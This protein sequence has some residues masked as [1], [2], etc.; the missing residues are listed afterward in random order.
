MSKTSTQ[1]GV[2]AAIE[3]VVSMQ[4]GKPVFDASKLTASAWTH[5]TEAAEAKDKTPRH[6]VSE[7]DAERLSS[8]VPSVI[9]VPPACVQERA[10]RRHL[11]GVLSHVR[12]LESSRSVYVGAYYSTTWKTPSAIEKPTNRSAD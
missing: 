6:C 7:A 5:A 9:A 1:E 4:T 2:K 12:T 8:V 3:A 10:G 11:G